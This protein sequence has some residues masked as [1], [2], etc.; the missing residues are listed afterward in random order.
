MKKAQGTRDK[1][2]PTEHSGR[3]F[4]E[5]RSFGRVQ[6][7]EQGTRRK[8]RYKIQDTRHKKIPISEEIGI[9]FLP[10]FRRIL[11]IPH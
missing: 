5:P 9:F 3:K 7:K 2:R 6:A 10:K 11:S 8:P 4:D 1:A